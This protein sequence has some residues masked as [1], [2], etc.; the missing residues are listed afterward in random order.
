M[1]P[2]AHSPGGWQQQAGP[3]AI[4]VLDAVGQLVATVCPGPAKRANADVITAAPELLQCARAA[5]PWLQRLL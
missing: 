5:T 1:S 4:K 2:A 3:S